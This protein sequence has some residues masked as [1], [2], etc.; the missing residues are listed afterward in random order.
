MLRKNT[1]ND[2]T[3]KFI[4]S[5]DI[6]VLRDATTK[7]ALGVAYSEDGLR[8]IANK[9]GVYLYCQGRVTDYFKA[10]TAPKA[11]NVLV[12]K[13][14]PKNFLNPSLATSEIAWVLAAEKKLNSNKSHYYEGTKDR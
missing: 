2:D 1:I 12:E 10:R 9:N 3:R 6:L 11:S 7:R 5:N 13:F 8:A 4:E 14:M